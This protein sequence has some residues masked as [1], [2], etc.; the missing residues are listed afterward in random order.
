[1]CVYILIELRHSEALHLTRS[2]HSRLAQ[3]KYFFVN[4][5]S[6]SLWVFDIPVVE[7]CKFFVMS[8]FLNFNKKWK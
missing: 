1:M 5:N 2:F 7:L 6:V 4:I 8:Q 3:I